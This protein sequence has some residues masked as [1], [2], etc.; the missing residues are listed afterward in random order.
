ML[1]SASG[2]ERV[3]LD[4]VTRIRHEGFHRSQ[5]MDLASELMDGIGP[6]VTGS[7]NMKAANE[8]ARGKFE[9][10]GLA[11]ARL[12]SWGP[13]GRGWTWDSCSV[14]ML[15][16]D[17]T[18]FIAIP[19]AWTPGTNGP[20]R[21]KAVRVNATVASDL[22]K[23]RGT[24]AGTAVLLGRREGTEGERQA[25]LAALRRERARGG[26]EPHDPGHDA[27]AIQPR[28]IRQAP[29]VIEGGPQ[30]LHRREGRRGPLRRL[31][32]WRNP[33]RARWRLL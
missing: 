29:R 24:L 13:F 19:Q 26:R 30:I 17:T 6:R 25:S 32:R 9:S 11:N 27:A 12:E 2:Q 31:T 7:P 18:Q 3:D 23:F 33:E 10:W 20:I 22:E 1:S 16:P 5:V 28:G 8:W 15:S 14:R 4:M 21:A